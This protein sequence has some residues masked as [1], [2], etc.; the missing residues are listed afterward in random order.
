MAKRKYS[1]I[2]TSVEFMLL[3]SLV[4]SID[5]IK[6]ESSV[7]GRKKRSKTV[8]DT[9][10]E[11]FADDGKKRNEIQLICAIIET[12]SKR[13]VEK[14]IEPLQ[15]LIPA[16]WQNLES[17]KNIY[18]KI[19]KTVNQ[20]HPELKEFYKKGLHISSLDSFDL[21][22][23]YN[24]KVYQ[25][26]I[27]QLQLDKAVALKLVQDLKETVR[28]ENLMIVIAMCVGS[29]MIEIA[30]L[31]KYYPLGN[32][33]NE[34]FVCGLAKCK[35][36]KRECM[37][38]VAGGLD[39]ND[40]IGLVEV[41][42]TCLQIGETESNSA[43]SSRL[44]KPLQKQVR[45]LFGKTMTFHKLRS[46]YAELAWEANIDKNLSKPA[47]YAKVLGHKPQ[48]LSTALSY[49]RYVINNKE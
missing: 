10:S 2:D 20:F 38:P 48:N 42:R 7:N 6:A 27:Q 35:D 25:R 19:R 9:L 34:I 30:K 36:E 13:T 14:I 18:V 8:V 17:R 33:L 40:I 5:M 37:R 43:I 39:A 15:K 12:G 47:F 41:V 29:R 16:I 49:Q 3:N 11:L 32:G 23:N 28:W 24:N 44:S 4:S 46:V 1:D 21:K 31:S 26:N 22:V 45:A